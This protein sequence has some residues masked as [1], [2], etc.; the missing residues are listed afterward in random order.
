MGVLQQQL[1]WLNTSVVTQ[2][3]SSSIAIYS[4]EWKALHPVVNMYSGLTLVEHQN[5]CQEK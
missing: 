2:I 5:K 1:K 3:S 4:A